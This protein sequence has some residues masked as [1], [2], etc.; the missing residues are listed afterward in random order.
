VLLAG[1]S[2]TGPGPSSQSGG[3]ASP[4]SERST[5]GLEARAITRQLRKKLALPDG[6]SGA[7]VVEVLPGSPAVA[8]GIH[9]ND[10]VEEIGSAR[11]R[12]I[13]EFTDA[14]YNRSSGPVR[15][16]YRRAGASSEATLI[17]ADQAPF[18]EESCRAGIASGCFRQAWTL[19][20]K[21]LGADRERA[22]GL[23]E[24][25]CRSGSAEACAYLG[26]RL[27]ENDDRKSEAIAALKRSCELQSGGGCATYAFLYATG[28]FVARDDRRAT[29][30]Y[31]KACDLG[32]ALGCYNAGL[33]AEDGRGTARDL[34]R[35]IVRYDEACEMGS[36]AACTNL[37]FLYENGH[38][39]RTDRAR[40]LALYQRGCDGTSC[41]RSNLNGCV[42]LGRGYRDGIGIEKSEERAASIF[43]EAC[44]R[45]LDPDD[46][47]AAE[48]GSRACS[49]LGALF[50]AGDG[51]GK[52]LARGR[53]LSELGCE[54]GDSFGCFNAAAVYTSGS[55]VE[56]DKT[57]AA[58]FL[59]KAC[60]GGDSEGC[61]DLGIA[62]EKGNSVPGDPRRASELFRK[63]CELGFKEACAKGKR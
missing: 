45:K 11:I 58:S 43:E 8:A 40:A 27:A 51:V 13:C 25:A 35:A 30:L 2:S 57:K 63:A 34:T 7:V 32:D 6:L 52:D 38:G 42:N 12:N 37:G 24:K 36:S 39:V 54:R 44:G 31:V 21:N 62:Y 46:P 49:L 19:G 10:V 1:C 17:P 18:Y 4:R 33:M 56:P 61:F 5:L 50:L 3:K 29:P 23:Y 59:E 16:V 53:E 47:G 55:G 60:G 22:L 26:L 28:K 14:A 41:Q 48:N 9:P 20:M 15:V